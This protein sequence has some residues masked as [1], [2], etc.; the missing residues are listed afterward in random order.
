LAISKMQL[1]NC[2]I[3]VF[4]YLGLGIVQLSVSFIFILGN[5]QLSVSF[6]FILSSKI[7]VI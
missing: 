5:V 4:S 1:A 2:F 7:I 6:I 3:D